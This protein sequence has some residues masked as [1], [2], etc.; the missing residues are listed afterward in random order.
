MSLAALHTLH[1][2]GTALTLAQSQRVAQA[3]RDIWFWLIVLAVASILVVAVSV[4]IGKLF[5]GP[6]EHAEGE[7]VF[8]LQDSVGTDGAN[9]PGDVFRL[10]AL[11]GVIKKFKIDH[12]VDH[13]AWMKPFT[14]RVQ[15][16]IHV[17][18][19]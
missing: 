14:N 18:A 1:L 2:S 17:R 9:R 7:T 19:R 12:V 10:Q 16:G 11:Q 3:Q 5:M 8:D 15:G 6:I 13:V 4:V